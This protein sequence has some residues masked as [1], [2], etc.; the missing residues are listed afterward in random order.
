MVFFFRKKVLH[1]RNSVYLG[2]ANYEVKNSAKKNLKVNECFS[3][4]LNGLE[5]VSKITKFRVFFS[6]TKWFEKRNIELFYL[7]RNGSER[8]SKHSQFCETVKCCA[9]CVLLYFPSTEFKSAFNV[10]WHGGGAAGLSCTELSIWEF[11]FCEGGSV[12]RGGLV[13]DIVRKGCP[14]RTPW[15]TCVHLYA[16]VFYRRLSP[17]FQFSLSPVTL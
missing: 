14:R 6:S 7:P 13:Y 16:F 2:I 15:T 11:P 17:Q 8:Y 1:L 3:L 10:Y 5:R 4:S 9:N 12:G